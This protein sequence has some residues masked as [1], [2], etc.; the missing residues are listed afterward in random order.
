MLD[1]SVA[2]QGVKEAQKKGSLQEFSKV[3]K[4]LFL[5]FVM[6]MP[7]NYGFFRT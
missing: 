1:F 3:A 6:H 7:W 2:N 4:S 5:H